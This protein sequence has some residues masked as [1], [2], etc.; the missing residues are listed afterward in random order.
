MKKVLVIDDKPEIRQMVS[1]MLSKQYEV[2]EF[3]KV[4]DVL[5]YCN[6]Q[7]ADI[8]ITDLLMPEKNGIDL[9]Q[10]IRELSN[11]IKILAISGGNRS[12]T[13]D[14]LP[15]A[16][17]VGADACLHKPFSPNELREKVYAILQ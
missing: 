16:D 14:F 15:V 8:L 13:C 6:Q 2:V 11:D 9:I 17:F 4:D 1:T 12:K 5:S 3:E 10:G 7:P